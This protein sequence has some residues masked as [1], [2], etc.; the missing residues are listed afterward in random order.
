MTDA[1]TSDALGGFCAEA[2]ISGT[3]YEVKT[4][5]INAADVDTKLANAETY[6]AGCA[7][8]DDACS[9][10]SD[11]NDECAVQDF[12]FAYTTDSYDTPVSYDVTT[13]DDSG[14]ETTTSYWAV[15]DPNVTLVAEDPSVS[16]A[17]DFTA[18]SF[19]VLNCSLT[20]IQMVCNNWVRTATYDYT[21]TDGVEHTD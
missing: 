8:S 21:D 12:L 1:L 20:S 4:W 6:F 15:S 13:T 14:T 17:S 3:T 9:S 19:D 10:T 18:T 7:C 5:S 16:S 2:N 11:S